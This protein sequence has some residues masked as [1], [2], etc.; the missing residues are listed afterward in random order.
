MVGALTGVRGRVDAHVDV[1]TR[2]PAAAR[3][4]VA[5]VYAIVESAPCHERAQRGEHARR[6]QARRATAALDRQDDG[7]ALARADGDDEPPFYVC[8]PVMA[9]PPPPPAFPSG[10]NTYIAKSPRS[11]D[12]PSTRH[13][14]APT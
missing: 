13:R 11:K 7:A 8:G 10:D 5:H 6:V 4:A 1:G 2:A 9:S 3:A 14:P 12:F